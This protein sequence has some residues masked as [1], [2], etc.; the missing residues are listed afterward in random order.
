MPLESL[1]GKHSCSFSSIG[2]GSLVGMLKLRILHGTVRWPF[3]MGSLV[4][5]SFTFPP[6]LFGVFRWDVF[7]K[8]QLGVDRLGILFSVLRDHRWLLE[9]GAWH[10]T[11]GHR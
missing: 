10:A 1:T 7:S 8:V 11:A 5:C 3:P 2:L 6:L 9:A 4:G